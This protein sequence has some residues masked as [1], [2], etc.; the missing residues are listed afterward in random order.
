MNILKYKKTKSR[1]GMN[2]SDQIEIQNYFK[3]Y[4]SFSENKKKRN[5][6]LVS[7]TSK[8]NPIISGQL[9]FEQKKW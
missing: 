9:Q 3:N 2:E 5:G 6:I 7:I 4:H 1:L 8:D